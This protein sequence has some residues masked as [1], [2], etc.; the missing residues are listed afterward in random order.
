MANKF[1][2][3]NIV[4]KASRHA[5]GNSKNEID[6]EMLAYAAGARKFSSLCGFTFVSKI[7][8][9]NPVFK[10]IFVAKV[11]SKIY[12]AKTVNPA[13]WYIEKIINKDT[14]EIID[15]I[16]L[17]SQYDF[18][19]KSFFESNAFKKSLDIMLGQIKNGMNDAVEFAK[20]LESGK[21]RMEA[22]KYISA[23]RESFKLIK[24]LHVYDK[25][26]NLVNLDNIKTD[27]YAHDAGTDL[28]Y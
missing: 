6:M 7:N 12:Q 2:L 20:S 26:H 22:N 15:A 14:V 23:L 25:R 18:D 24:D 16:Q 11:R 5:F 21:D 1:E 10:I 3:K 4:S 8:K 9:D 13:A 19:L 17:Y 27:K 28:K